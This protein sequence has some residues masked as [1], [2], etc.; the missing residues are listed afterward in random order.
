MKII[1]QV[2]EGCGI[3]ECGICNT[4]YE[5]EGKD[6]FAHVKNLEYSSVDIHELT[7]ADIENC[8]HTVYCDKCKKDVI[9]C[10]SDVF[11]SE[12]VSRNDFLKEVL[13]ASRPKWFRSIEYLEDDGDDF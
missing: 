8:K 7:E 4:I 3:V 9:V 12:K 2:K 1:G 11:Y 6:V 13:K 10:L 5:F